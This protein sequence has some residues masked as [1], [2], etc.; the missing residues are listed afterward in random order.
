MDNA[1]SLADILI[2]RAINQTHRLAYRFLH[3]AEDEEIVCS[4]GELDR[5][6]RTIAEMLQS[7]SKPGDRALLLY[8][9][10]LDFIFAFFGCLY[11]K[12]IPIPAYPPHPARLERTLPMIRGIVTDASPQVALVTSVLRDAVESKTEIISEFPQMNW[13]STDTLKEQWSETREP[14]KYHS[15]DLAFIQYTSGST[16][17]PKG[18]M[19]SHGNILHNLGYI[20]GVFGLSP[21]CNTV[22]WLPPYHDMGLIG[23]IFQGLYSGYPVNIFSHFSFLQKPYRWLEAVSR[24]RAYASGAPNFAYDLCVKKIKPEQRDSLDLSG[25]RV[26]F[27]GAEK[28]HYETLRKFAEYFA[29]CGFSKRAFLPCYGLAE[30]TLMVTGVQHDNLPITRNLVASE[31]A[32]NKVRIAEN[33]NAD[34]VTAV[35]CGQVST[36]QKIFIV[37]PDTG[38]PCAD[39]EIGE[40]WVSGKSKTNG[41]WNKPLETRLAF[42]A[43]LSTHED[44]SFL[45]T[46][47]MGFIADG[48]LFVTGRIKDLIISAGN[49]HY[50]GDIEKTVEHCHSAIRAMGCVAFSTTRGEEEKLVIL[51]ELDHKLNGQTDELMRTINS[52]VAEKHEL[53]VFDIR[54]L[55]LGELRRTSSGKLKRSLCRKHYEEG[56]FNETIEI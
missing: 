34:A 8:P 48:E 5:K 47:D 7:I 51:V 35:G 39:D 10:G 42:D 26:A 52:S 1:K 17:D 2:W 31:L 53:H 15:Q 46:G 3:E 40:I 33:G 29:P 23:G 56:Q 27:N 22:F 19:V 6:A 18:V 14:L 49:N 38:I 50:P 44:D 12:I 32:Q 28:V 41:Y 4:Y 36:D 25:W 11:A 13:Q 54:F 55:R 43:Y 30:G 20:E 21:A 24:F 37:N 9:P 16:G 45:R